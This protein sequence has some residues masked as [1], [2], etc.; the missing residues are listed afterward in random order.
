[1]QL[2]STKITDEFNTEWDARDLAVLATFLADNE[3]SIVL[4]D[5]PVIHVD[6]TKYELASRMTETIYDA[7]GIMKSD[8]DSGKMIHMMNVVPITSLSLDNARIVDIGKVT[9]VDAKEIA[10]LPKKTVYRLRYVS[11]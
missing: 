11:I 2:D 4:V 5:T 9:T 8:I 6:Q 7:V 10:N 1:M 3:E